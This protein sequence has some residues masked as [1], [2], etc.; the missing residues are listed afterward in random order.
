LVV[1]YWKHPAVFTQSATGKR[2]FKVNQ[3]R[4]HKNANLVI[5]ATLQRMSV[6]KGGKPK[7]YMLS[8]KKNEVTS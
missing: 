5:A 4:A 6:E 1:G 2:Q 8:G 3:E 7:K